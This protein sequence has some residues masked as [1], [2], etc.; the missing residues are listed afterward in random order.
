MLDGTS[1]HAY[2]AQIHQ[3]LTFLAARHLN[4]CLEGSVVPRIAPL[5]VRYVAR[6]NVRQ[7]ESGWLRG[8]FRSDFYDRAG[9]RERSWMW[10]LDTRVHEQFRELREELDDADTPAERYAELG[11][12][13]NILQD[14]SVPA[15]VVPVYFTRWW[16][17]NVSDKFN[18]Y[19]VDPDRVSRALEGDCETLLAAADNEVETLMQQA[20]D[21]T[22]RAVQAPIEGLPSTWQAFWRL[23]DDPDSF[24]E[25]G[26]AGNSFG[27]RAEFRCNGER[28]VLLDRDP[29]Y[30]AFAL[31]RHVM[32]VV[33]TARALLAEQR[34][35]VTVAEVPV[36]SS[37]PAP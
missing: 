12:V 11:R 2:E 26:R 30:A 17:F 32:A 31:D 3:Q 19:P 36:T 22:L 8:V 29:L 9:Q 4:E 35:Y 5:E 25:Y 14:M 20:A 34:R 28:C 15:H 27:R 1:A 33:T 18:E 13:I 7:E 23:A 37:T 10:V 6:A 24:G 21:D 16:R